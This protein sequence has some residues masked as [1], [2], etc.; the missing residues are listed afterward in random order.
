MTNVYVKE[1]LIQGDVNL[2]VSHIY[3][4]LEQIIDEKIEQPEKKQKLKDYLKKIY[5]EIKD[6]GTDAI[7]K[8]LG[9][10]LKG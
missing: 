3:H 9:G 10:V 5:E 8:T 4:T 7:S 6:V 1:N 2:T